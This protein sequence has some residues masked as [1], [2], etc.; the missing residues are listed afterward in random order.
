MSART[1]SWPQRISIIGAAGLVG[2]SAAAS[3]ATQGIGQEL[4]LQDRRD[5]LVEA[6]RIDL[7]DAQAVLG[8]DRPRI[9]AGS[10]DQPV[11]L[12][13]VAASLPETPDGDRRD[14]L[15]ANAQLL[16]SLAEQIRREAGDEG[17]VLLLTNPVDILADWLHRHHGF[18]A[19]RL[20]GY[21]LNDSARFRRAIARELGT[22][23]TSVTA[24]VLG[25]HGKGQV[26]VFSSVRVDGQ[27]VAWPDGAVDRVRADVDGWFERWSRLK[28]GRSSGWAS[29][30]G[31]MHL[32]RSLAAGGQV[33]TTASTSGIDG[34]PETFMAL[35]THLVEGRPRAVLPELSQQEFSAL[36]EAGESIRHT[37]LT[38]N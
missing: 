9:L 8:V 19:E 25:E 20:I 7:S 18:A 22:E 17:L 12:V 1:P 38:L 23:V 26:P 15:A 32:I 3:L 10:P 30:A 35:P 14:F 2:S 16:A 36:Q 4:Y 33:I 13:V 29:G 21:A 24:S 34:L 37:A 31:V 27:P 5:N 28:P 11:D 6:H